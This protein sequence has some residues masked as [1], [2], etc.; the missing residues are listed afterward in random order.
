M[1]DRARGHLVGGEEQRR[2]GIAGGVGA[3]ALLAAPA[4]RVDASH[5]PDGEAAAAKAASL[6]V[7]AP[8]LEELL[9]R[10]VDDDQVAVA[11]AAALVAGLAFERAPGRDGNRVEVAI[12]EEVV[13][14]GLEGQKG[15]VGARLQDLDR[16]VDLHPARAPA[17]PV[18]IGDHRRRL[19]IERSLR[20][21]G[22][23]D[24]GG[25]E[26][27]AGDG[28][29]RRS[30]PGDGVADVPSLPPQAAVAARAT[31]PRDRSIRLM[32]PPGAARRTPGR[33]P[34]RAR[35]PRSAS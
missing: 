6:D 26:E 2:D 19:A 12:G 21:V 22:G 18:E 14:R 4:R 7:G 25:R 10:A 1:V 13:L 8:H 5:V 29:G 35:S 11:V 20:D 33:A 31:A 16:E 24:G 9:A 3:R 28:R 34:R 23:P 32:G 30:G 15:R 17:H 27:A